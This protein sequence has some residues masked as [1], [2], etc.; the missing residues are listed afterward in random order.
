MTNDDNVRSNGDLAGRRPPSG[1]RKVAAQGNTSISAQHRSRHHEPPASEQPR[2]VAAASRSVHAGA[3]RAKNATGKAIN[4]SVEGALTASTGGTATF[5]YRIIPKPTDSK[6]E[7]QKKSRRLLIAGGAVLAFIAMAVTFAF[8]VAL[9]LLGVLGAASGAMGAAGTAANGSCLDFSVPRI[10]QGGPGGTAGVLGLPLDEHN[11]VVTSSFGYRDIGVGTNNH[12]GTD[13]AGPGIHGAPIYAVG[14]G[15]VT[16]AGP[17]SGYGNWVVIRHDI[18]GQVVDS[19]YG[20]M[21]DGHVYVQKGDQV[22]AGQH[23]ADVGNSGW[24]SGAHL[25]LGMYPGGWA[26]GQ[27][28]DPMPWLSKFKA[29]AEPNPGAGAES[30]R[31]GADVSEAELAA[32]RP[33]PPTGAQQQQTLNAEQQGN[34]AAIIAAARESDLEPAARAAVIA[35]TLAG[36]ATNFISQPRNG[37]EPVGIFAERPLGESNI[38]NLTNPKYAATQFFNRLRTYSEQN[39]DWATKPVA[40]VIIGVHPERASLQDQ[41]MAWETQ[42]VDTVAALWAS[43]QAQAGSS[44]LLMAAGTNPDCAVGVVNMGLAP[45]AVPP[46]YADIIAQAGSVCADIPPPF[47]AAIIEQESGWDPGVTS[48]GDGV[49][50]GGA[51]GMTQFMPGTWTQWGRDSGLDRSGRTERGPTAPDPFNAYDSILS[52]GH[53]TCHL[54]DYLKPHIDSGQV[55]GDLLDLVAASYNAGPGAV[56]RYGGIPPYGQT[57]AYVPSVRTKMNKYAQP[58]PGSAA[59]PPAVTGGSE[60]GRVVV[61]AAMRQLGQPYVWGGGDENGPTLG[62]PDPQNPGSPGFDCSGLVEYATAQ[63]SNNAATA[64]GSTHAQVTQGR[65]IAPHD[66]QPGDA[67][68]SN[69]TS[70]VAIWV[71]DGKVIE[72]PTFGQAVSI[73]NFDLANAENIRRYG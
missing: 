55:R 21:D 15:V 50:S 2:G 61:E 47:I 57:Q 14:D 68:F 26:A 51:Q 17:A 4:R 72:A 23:I 5:L 3:V 9:S 63:A 8:M 69:G 33:Y 48:A 56:V 49:N 7:R 52:A 73:N 18:D 34:V 36:Q 40:D 37:T 62:I 43:E 11:M 59:S 44:G 41:F 58:T 71:G 65:E 32:M 54:A 27:G 16:E 10:A 12:D 30:G 45:G 70:H 13:L 46:E 24:S 20:H 66:I 29:G 6:E 53:Y 38:D 64:R 1:G 67:V 60:F 39:P 35:T 28:V 19:L 25:H 22:K 31:S 42:A